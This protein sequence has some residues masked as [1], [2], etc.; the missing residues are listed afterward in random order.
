LLK[1]TTWKDKK[2]DKKR[3]VKGTI[4]QSQFNSWLYLIVLKKEGLTVFTYYGVKVLITTEWHIHGLQ[5]DEWT[6]DMEDNSHRQLTRGSHPAWGLDKVT[7][8]Y[9]SRGLRLGLIL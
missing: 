9:V 6:P 4:G 8:T 3:L 1:K 5:V 7:V 2:K